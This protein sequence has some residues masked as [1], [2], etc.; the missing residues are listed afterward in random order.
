MKQRWV[1]EIFYEDADGDGLSSHIPFIT[2]PEDEEMPRMLFIFESRETGEFEPG[3][4]GDRQLPDRPLDARGSGVRV[5][6]G[7]A[8]GITLSETAREDLG[9][10]EYSH[11]H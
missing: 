8:S 10:L 11:T 9:S 3:Q 2:V 6:Q 5:P 7:C 4:D 1:P